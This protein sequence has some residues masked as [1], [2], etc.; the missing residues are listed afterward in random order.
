MPVRTRLIILHAGF[1]LTGIVTTFLG[2]LIPTFEARWTLD[3]AQAG[4]LFAAQFLGSLAGAL[5]SGRIVSRLGLRPSV[6]AGYLIMS[7]GVTAAAA[8]QWTAGLAAVA[9]YG[10][11]LG[12]TIPST[13]LLVADMCP[14]RRA[15]ALNL[16]NVSWGLGA[17]A[18]PPLVVLFL[19]A[20]G[21][22][23][24]LTAIGGSLAAIAALSW[25]MDRRPDAMPARS[26]S[27]PVAGATNQAPRYA[28]VR[29]TGILLF[30][31]VGV[32]NG[33]AGWMPSLA[34]REYRL[35]PA[36][37]AMVQA[38]F[39]GA[40]LAGRLLAPLALRRVAPDTLIVLGLSLAALGSGVLVAIRDVNALF[41]GALATGAGLSFVFP[42][43]IAVFSERESGGASRSAGIVF[44]LAALGGAGIPWAVG[45][46]STSLHSLR[47]A[48]TGM[49]ACT[50]AMILVQLR[51]VRSRAKPAPVCLR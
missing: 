27:R 1:V 35:P 41:A 46:V 18:A 28:T 14:G 42:T 21:P 48:M 32:E 22:V 8:N 49:L 33:T 39:W 6:V 47:T 7:L 44:G 19:R 5:S 12:L 26:E 34:L 3:D 38:N 29:M 4:R 50:V 17:L 23:P 30:L 9:C 51:L 43:A 36:V 31:Y 24:L 20:G 15:A 45:Y 13:N 16:L 37:G 2:P 10:V 11:G 25:L 40:L